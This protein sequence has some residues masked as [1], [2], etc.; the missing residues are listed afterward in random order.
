[1]KTTAKA[2]V[3]GI[4]ELKSLPQVYERVTEA[5]NRPD[6][7]A[8]IIGAVVG[9]DAG[10]TMRLLRIVNSSL[11]GFPS[12]IETISRAITLVGVEE[13][14]DLTLA[15]SVIQLFD[16]LPTE[17]TNMESYWRHSLATAICCRLIAEHRNESNIE[18]FFVGGLLHDVGSLALWVHGAQRAKRIARRCQSSGC[19]LRDAE[20][21]VLSFDHTDVGRELLTMWRLPQSLVESVYCHHMPKRA[22]SVPIEA[23]T[24]HVSEIIVDAMQIGSSGEVNVPPTVINAWETLELEIGFL[25]DLIKDLDSQFEEASK[26]ILER[27]SS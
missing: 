2:F 27:A 4:P 23:M 24:I 17:F 25:G 6:S 19:Q 20:R 26:T 13:L 11:Y 12:K 1:M 14:R 8:E 21:A 9:E 7:S 15:T 10:L 5:I 18:R 22:T 16:S 3:R